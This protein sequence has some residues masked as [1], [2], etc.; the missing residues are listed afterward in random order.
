MKLSDGIQRAYN[1]KWSMINTFTVKIT[2]AEKMVNAKKITQFDDI[3]MNIVSIETP[4]FTNNPIQSFVAN[5]WR[6]H[7][8]HDSLY[9]F[10]ITFRDQDQMSLYRK[11]M[12]IYGFTK[13]N[14]FDDCKLNIK[15]S[16]DADW[17]DEADSLLFEFDGCLIEAVSQLSFSNNTE[18]QI[19]EFSVSFKCN[20]AIVVPVQGVEN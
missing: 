19:A 5:R 7:N 1:T 13:E 11:F 9:Q 17:V 12:S 6:I 2:A 16:K 20:S 8:G 4:Q 3:N 18:N 15:I 10:T 14:Y